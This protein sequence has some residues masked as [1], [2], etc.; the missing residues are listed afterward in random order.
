[1]AI[2]APE[3]GEHALA[4]GAWFRASQFDA[5]KTP[6]VQSGFSAAQDVLKDTVHLKISSLYKCV[7]GWR[8]FVT[9]DEYEESYSSS[10]ADE[11][12]SLVGRALP[13]ASGERGRSGER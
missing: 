8:A 10:S 12:D 5:F 6:G 13:P 1:M 2:F 7:S 3:D 11:S 4:Y 9:A